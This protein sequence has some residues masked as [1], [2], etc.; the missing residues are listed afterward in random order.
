MAKNIAMCGL[1]CGECPAYIAYVTDDQALR[2]KTA[3]EWAKEYGTE[4]PAD[5]I[6]CVGCTRRDGVH[7][8]YCHECGVRTCG[9]GKNAENCAACAEYPCALVAGFHEKAPQAKANI[10]GLRASAKK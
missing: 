9:L 8:G 2:E 7:I 5:M 10:E 4:I 6:N 3:A 1:D